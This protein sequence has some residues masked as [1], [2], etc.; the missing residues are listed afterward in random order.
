[1][2]K[3]KLKF[4]LNGK[5]E[6]DCFLYGCKSARWEIESKIEKKIKEY[7]KYFADAVKENKK[8]SEDIFFNTLTNL[9]DLKDTLCNSEKKGDLEK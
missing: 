5:R 9:K 8:H 2:T 1:M 4:E 3:K 6:I 7:E